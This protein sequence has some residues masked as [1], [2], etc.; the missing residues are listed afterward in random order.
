MTKHAGRPS[1]AVSEVP[2]SQCVLGSGYTTERL[3]YTN[4]ALTYLS[5]YPRAQLLGCTRGGHDKLT[6][7]IPE[8]PDCWAGSAACD[9]VCRQRIHYTSQVRGL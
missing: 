8:K 7:E 6:L 9:S 4:D 3:I 2:K 5:S 1:C